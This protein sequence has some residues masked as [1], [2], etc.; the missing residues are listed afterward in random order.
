MKLPSL[1]SILTYSLLCPYL[2][3]QIILI[4]CYADDQLALLAF[5]N[6][7]SG[8]PFDTL[9]S[10]N[11]TVGHCQW[12]GVTCSKR[13]P[14]RVTALSLDSLN[15]AGS[16]S[17]SLANL[18]FLQRLNLPNN[19][20]RGRIPSEL[21]GLPRLQYLNLSMNSLEGEI[22][23]SLSHCISFQ[24][25]ILSN[26][27]LSGEIPGELGNV[28]SLEAIDLSNNTISGSIPSSFGHLKSLKFL[29]LNNNKLVG[30][31][32]SFNNLSSIT[33]VDLSY[34]NLTGGISP[35]FGNHSSLVSID[36]T[37]NTLSGSIPASLGNLP[38]LTSLSLTGNAFSG[39]IPASL[40]YLPSLR[41]LA[42]SHNQLSGSVPSSIYNSSTLEH[43]GLAD[44]Q[45]V[46]TLPPDFGRRLPALQTLLLYYN[47]F[48]GP[49]PM[50]LANASEL[51]DIELTGNSFS[52]TIPSNLGNL[53]KLFWLDLDRNEFDARGVGGWSFLA[54]LTNCI[55]LQDLSL[56]YNGPNGLGGVLP[57]SVANLSTNLQWLALGGNKIS[58]SIPAEIGNLV[59]L[60]VLGMDMNLLTGSIPASI[61][62]LR[63][64][65]ELYLSDNKF[66]GPIPASLG[67]LTKLNKLGIADSALEGSIPATLGD[68]QA[69]RWLNI[70]NNQLTG[71]IPP[72]LVSISSLTEF[73]DLSHNFLTGSLPVEVGRL[74]NLVRFYVSGN[75]LSGEIPGSI[76]E[77]Q[78]LNT[79]YMDDNLFQGLI[80]SSVTNLKG[81]QELDLS[82]NNLSGPI[83]KF[84]QDFSFLQYLNLSSNNFEGE[85]PK[86]GIFRN[87]SA[88]S[89]LGNSGL[90]GGEPELDLPACPS[91]AGGKMAGSRRIKVIILVS[92]VSLCCILLACLLTIWYRVYRR[93]TPLSESKEEG[94]IMKVSY[95]Q[96]L[97]ATD[98]LSPANLI[99][100]GSFGSVYRGVMNFGQDKIVAVKVLS[101][102]Q[103][104]ASKS[105]LA[106]CNALKSIRH[107]NLIKMLTLC[108]SIDS[109]GNDFKALVF[110]YMPNGNLDKWLHPGEEDGGRN[111]SLEQSLNIA[112]D[113]AFALDYLHHYGPEPIVHCDLKPS[114]VLLDDDMT[115][116]VA[117]FGLSKFLG[118]TI[119]KANQSSTG[120]VGVKGTIGYVAP[121]YGVANQVSTEG[122]VYSYGVLLLE[123]FTGR[124]PTDENLKEGLDLHKFVE[125]A[126][127]EHVMDIVDPC[128]L[129]EGNDRASRVKSQECLV[130][131][132][133]I[134]L[135]CSKQSS[136]ERMQMADVV[137][138]MQAIRDVFT[139]NQ[140]EIRNKDNLKGECSSRLSL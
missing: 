109:R 56:D 103:K 36:V 89:V 78:L 102:Q 125:A 127:P 119:E 83:P 98:G 49:L 54:S 1:Y 10:W 116:H 128:L 55:E 67:N 79:L 132:L 24:E 87:L 92:V 106:E 44:N 135:S 65:Q 133:R 57:K 121:E 31:I 101:L 20:L 39:P 38:Y 113:V 7:I 37:L 2:L 28:S 66:S 137:R 21:G 12:P 33:Y 74:K 23:P 82:H 8:D 88:V 22:P 60:N 17:P 62:E 26:N 16:V 15:L 61:G 112:M 59:N 71:T 95:S 115:A 90:C 139:G 50:S 105:F 77:C 68:C 4:Q 99:G 75:K 76:G 72:E 114:N 84:L 134:G 47:D 96:I 58:G 138:E 80:P 126:Y 118:K 107:R 81:I 18:T 13:H 5:K 93:R 6:A 48:H 70:S 124:R 100:V 97:Q 130:S 91:K 43:L 41:S 11:D 34:N 122:D 85:V 64:L 46:G 9:A 104:G 131:V 86:T 25:L 40:G 129:F 69:L 53:Q 32:P 111:L 14:G 120:S 117:D 63:Q 29:Y 27:Q 110:E 52:G 140:G 45:L 51:T 73:V 19:Q 30:I 42:L 136:R 123:M 108:S 94:Q 3:I 35:S